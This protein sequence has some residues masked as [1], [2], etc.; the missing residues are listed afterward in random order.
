M[1][2]AAVAISFWLIFL[3]PLA[4]L[5]R[6]NTQILSL[7][8]RPFGASFRFQIVLAYRCDR[9]DPKIPKRGNAQEFDDQE[10]TGVDGLRLRQQILHADNRDDG[11]RLQHANRLVSGRRHD[12]TYC[13]RED[14]GSQSL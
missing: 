2:C 8:E 5:R 7:F 12:Q 4:A 1:G 6:P 11:T 3:A 14:H 13:L 10:V 9:G